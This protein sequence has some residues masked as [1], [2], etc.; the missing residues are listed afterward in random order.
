ML[1]DKSVDASYCFECVWRRFILYGCCLMMRL[2]MLML[3]YDD[4]S[5]LYVVLWWT[6]VSRVIMFLFDVES[7]FDNALLKNR[8]V[9]AV[10]VKFTW[11]YCIWFSF[12]KY[13]TFRIIA[14]RIR[15]M[16]LQQLIRIYYIFSVNIVI[17]LNVILLYIAVQ[18]CWWAYAVLFL[19]WHEQY[20]YSCAVWLDIRFERFCMLCLILIVIYIFVLCMRVSIYFI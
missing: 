7:V 4:S 18:Y 12:I 8:I 15:R 13:N 5:D 17:M 9:V 6:S 10:D 1:Y 14:I 19:I 11:F 20:R 2:A 16:R 3:L